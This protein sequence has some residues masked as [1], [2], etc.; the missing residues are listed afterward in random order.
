MNIIPISGMSDYANRWFSLEVKSG[1][2]QTVVRKSRYIIKVSFACLSQTIQSIHRLGGNVLN[3]TML[4]MVLPS[5]VNPVVQAVDA[6]TSQS[7]VTLPKPTTASRSNTQKPATPP[8]S[9]PREPDKGGRG[10]RKPNN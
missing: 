2:S 3:V 10:K 1:H 9:P 6:T 8:P 7:A 5:S 4:S